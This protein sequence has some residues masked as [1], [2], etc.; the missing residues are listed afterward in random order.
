MEQGQ[1]QNI[2]GDSRI[3]VRPGRGTLAFAGL[4]LLALAG[5]AAQMNAPTASHDKAAGT[6]PWRI[7]CETARSM[8]EPGEV[9][10][11]D[12]ERWI[13]GRD[14][15]GD[16]AELQGKLVDGFFELH[17]VAATANG[18]VPPE[19]TA[20]R[21][22]CI[23]TIAARQD[24]QPLVLGWVMAAREHE[25]IEVPIVY[26]KRGAPDHISRVVIFGDS[27][28]DSGRLKRRLHVFPNDP[29]WLGRFSNGPVW[30]EY[31][32]M[33]TDLSV[34]NNAYG[35]ASVVYLEQLPGAGMVSRVR[36][37]GQMFVSG[38]IDLQISDYLDRS[39]NGQGVAQ[40][41]ETLFLIW[42]GANDYISKEP[43]SGL[44]TTFL[45]SP[46]GESGYR[47]VVEQAVTGLADHVRTLYAAGARRFLLI[48][49]PDLGRSPIV[50]Q[51]TTYTPELASTLDEDGRRLELARRLTELTVYHNER[52]AQVIAQLQPELPEA[53]IVLLDEFTQFA[54][55]TGSQREA[56]GLDPGLNANYDLNFGYDYS[57]SETVLRT[58]QQALHLQK[59]CYSGAY[60][61][62]RDP[63]KI[64]AS[65][66]RTVFWDIVHPTTLTH[67]WQA[68]FVSQAMHDAG[69]TGSLP[70]QQDYLDWCRSIV[71]KVTFGY[72]S[73]YIVEQDASDDSPE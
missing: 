25:E 32:A 54:K 5:C 47:T 11:L 55:L 49:L 67:C 56:P 72:E 31:L 19:R 3:A 51:N 73:W 60:L 17:H 71:G 39:L 58:G 24:E 18:P 37:Y 48:D 63:G 70:N 7:H 29:Y 36:E 6:E 46:E 38:S 53:R 52:L 68:Y 44:I 13:R 34:Q 61:G 8:Q 14:Q 33:S 30:P 41:S 26:R 23:D 28:T 16:P 69:W 50:L 9:A 20:L 1:R 21:K 62:T 43:V 22:I 66:E 15:A 2:A 42:A 64:C 10:D 57:A 4:V 27:L 35:G 12:D 40:P 59:P 45:N 65:P